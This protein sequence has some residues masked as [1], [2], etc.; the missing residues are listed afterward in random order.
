MIETTSIAILYFRDESPDEAHAYLP[1]GITEDLIIHLSRLSA[2]RVAAR[3]DVL[4]FRGRDVA[5]TDLGDALVTDH[6]LDGSVKR[7]DQSIVI[8][9][10]LGEVGSGAAVWE[11]RFERP[12]DEI[13]AVLNEI[14]HGVARSLEVSVEDVKAAELKPV[15][16][17]AYDAYLHGRD[18]L[19]K[20]GR[21][22][23][24]GA[25]VCFAD[26]TN[27]D[28]SFAL[29]NLGAAQAAVEMFTF[30]DDDD[31]WLDRALTSIDCALELDPPL[32]EARFLQG[33]VNYH[34]DHFDKAKEIFA[35]VVDGTSCCYDAYRWLGIVSDVTGKYDEALSYYETAAKVKPYSVEPWLFMNMTHRRKGDMESALMSARRFLEVGIRKL[36][37][38]PDDEVTLSRFA[39]IYTLL[40][41]GEKARN[42]LE[43][44]LKWH[45]D[46]GTVLYNC[47]CT[48]ALLGDH[49]QAI[50]CLRTALD[51]GYRNVREWVKTDPDF[52]ELRQTEAFRQ[53]LVKFDNPR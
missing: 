51:H 25:I 5:A 6:V 24:E 19:S 23:V 3:D 43:R 44:I 30:Y 50:L 26:S 35:Q 52:A 36:E 40:G 17:D 34:R 47:A 32:N 22:N 7:D 9:A 38:N 37:I 29:A 14:L 21:K 42:A 12:H 48:Y 53:L 49:E 13:V 11:G 8:T 4:P 31:A 1:A 27:S 28:K 46:D 18:L 16:A 39:A 41:E 2:V 45:P 10:R 33:I 15:K 20:R